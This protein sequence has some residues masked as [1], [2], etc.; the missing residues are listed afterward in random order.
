[1]KAVSG[2]AWKIRMGTGARCSAC[3]ERITPEH[4]EIAHRA[5][6]GTLLRFHE[7]C[8]RIWRAERG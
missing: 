5:G 4:V 3:D 7:L 2:T 6:D 1:M 8:E